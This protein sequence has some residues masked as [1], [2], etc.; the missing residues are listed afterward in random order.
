M[1]TYADTPQEELPRSITFDTELEREAQRPD[2][3]MTVLERLAQRQGLLGEDEH[4]RKTRWQPWDKEATVILPDG[5][6]IV[7]E[8]VV[9][10]ERRKGKSRWT[11][12]H[13][14]TNLNTNHERIE[15]KALV[16]LEL[17]MAS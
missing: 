6:K 13:D 10:R 15:Y 4:V 9:Q 8:L 14:V 3:L 2:L 17:A 16:R 5:R 1:I 11:T 12:W 7:G